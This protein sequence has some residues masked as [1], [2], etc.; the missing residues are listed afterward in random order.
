[1]VIIMTKHKIKNSEY[2]ILLLAAVILRA[3]FLISVNGFPERLYYLAAFNESFTFLF[4]TFN[5]PAK[6]AA[7]FIFYFYDMGL[8]DFLL[9]ELF[10]VII[11]CFHF[12]GKERFLK[13]LYASGTALAVT[14]FSRLFMIFLYKYT[15]GNLSSVIKIAAPLIIYIIP[16]G[17]VVFLIFKSQI[18]KTSDYIKNSLLKPSGLIALISCFILISVYV[19]AIL[20]WNDER[21]KYEA[22][23]F[24]TVDDTERLL[25]Y[26]EMINTFGYVTESLFMSLMT[27]CFYRGVRKT[28]GIELLETPQRTGEQNESKEPG[29]V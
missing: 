11:I 14:V 21:L 10:A 5:N 26:L 23:P 19:V 7:D 17:A 13:I 12:K 9:I 15:S 16:I 6:L 22:S 2:Y 27:L 3:V 28:A 25:R 4:L 18:K 24:S 8:A 20:I 1:M 29:L